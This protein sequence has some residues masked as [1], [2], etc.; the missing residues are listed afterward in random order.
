MGASKKEIRKWYEE[1]K[2]KEYYYLAVCCDS[3]N[4]RYFPAFADTPSGIDSIS[5]ELKNNHQFVVSV[6][7]LKSDLEKQLDSDRLF[8]Y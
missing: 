3:A 5:E 7:K 1:G 6:Y 4:F 2:R 8:N